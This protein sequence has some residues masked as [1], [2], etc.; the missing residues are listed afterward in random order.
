VQAHLRKCMW[1]MCGDDSLTIGCAFEG[2]PTVPFTTRSLLSSLMPPAPAAAADWATSSGCR[3]RAAVD[4]QHQGCDIVMSSPGDG[5]AKGFC[6][7]RD[8]TLLSHIVQRTHSK[9]PHLA[10]R[11]GDG[12]PARARSWAACCRGRCA[13]AALC[14]LHVSPAAGNASTICADSRC[15]QSQPAQ[16][17]RSRSAM[18][19]LTCLS[20]ERAAGPCCPVREHNDDASRIASQRP[21]CT[22]CSTSVYL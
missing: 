7:P 4:L 5:C 9:R 12:R 17:Q 20:V 1:T 16:G 13:P 2:S 10:I 6:Q 22:I 3:C 19:L 11:R 18:C 14:R 15:S 8:M 21:L